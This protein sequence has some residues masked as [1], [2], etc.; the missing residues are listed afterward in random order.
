MLEHV[1]V[2]TEVNVGDPSGLDI[3]FVD[4][5]WVVVEEYEVVKDALL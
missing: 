3:L 1:C 5:E 2:T 4:S